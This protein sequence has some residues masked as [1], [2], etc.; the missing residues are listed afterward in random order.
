MVLVRQWRRENESRCNPL[1]GN[2]LKRLLQLE[3]VC[4]TLV[5]AKWGA[6]RK[7]TPRTLIGCQNVMRVQ[8]LCVTLGGSTLNPSNSMELKLAVNVMLLNSTT[9]EMEFET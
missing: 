2:G 9:L 1:D 7:Q 3:A 6:K 8:D 5:A 4:W